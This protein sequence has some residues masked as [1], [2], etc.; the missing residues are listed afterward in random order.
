MNVT[1][2]PLLD[3]L[4]GPWRSLQI[5]V[6]GRSAAVGTMQ[7][8]AMYP[9]S[10]VTD[11]KRQLWIQMDGDPRWA[12]E[13][14]FIGVPQTDDTLRP[15]EFHWSIAVGATLPDPRPAAA[16][17][18]SPALVDEAGNR[19]PIAPTMLGALTLEA[20]LSV[21]LQQG[22]PTLVA[23]CLDELAPAL[24]AD[25]TAQLYQGFYQLYF[26]W[27][28]APEQVLNASR[29]TEAI[30]V[31]YAAAAA[32][33][34]GRTGRIEMVQAALAGNRYI[35][36][37][38]TMHTMVRL[39]W[40]LPIPA[41]RPDS[42]ER[43]FYSLRATPTLPFLRYF[44]PSGKGTPILK[45]GLKDDGAMVIEDPKVMT[46]YLSQPAP[47]TKGGVILGRIPLAS[48]HAETGAAFTLYM[49]EDG[50]TDITFEV[51]QRGATYIAA[52]A[53]DA[54]RVLARV[55]EEMGFPP[56]TQPVLRD[57]HATYN[58][59]HP[60]TR[61]KPISY[62]VL[63]SRVAGLT[64]FFDE[65]PLV[66]QSLG[67]FTWRATSNY[68]SESAIFTYITQFAQVD[69]ITDD[70]VMRRTRY[71]A[72]IT[73]KFGISPEQAA[74]TMERWFERRTAAVAPVP[75]VGAGALAVPK[76]NTG[77]QIVIRGS[78][79]DYRIELQG[80]DNYLEL[81]RVLSVTAVV[82][83]A[84]AEELR[85]SSPSA[86]LAAMDQ[87]VA[88]EDA[89]VEDS[90]AAQGGAPPEEA[91][92]D[93]DQ[94]DAMM[95]FMEGAE[96]GGAD[97]EEASAAAS[98]EAPAAAQLVS[99]AAAVEVAVE[100]PDLAAAV[101]AVSE[102]C[103]GALTAPGEPAL[104]IKPEYYISRLSA[105]D[106]V[107]F[108]YK[109]PKGATGSKKSYARSCQAPD[110]RQPDIMSLAEY[111]RIQ[112][113]YEG[114]VRFVNLPPQNPDDLPTYPDYNPKKK[115]SDEAFKV[116]PATTLPLW[117]VLRTENL[118]TPGTFNYL[119]C[120]EL[121][122]DRDN[123]P[124][125]TSEFESTE[126][127]GFRKPENTC[128][129]CGGNVIE[130]LDAP[131]PG[132]TVIKR[133]AK[134]GQGKVHSFI[135]HLSRGITHPEKGV[136]LPCCHTTPSLLKYYLEEAHYGRLKYGTAAQAAE[137][138]EEEYAEAPP[139]QQEEVAP[140]EEPHTDY[141]AIL[142]SMQ[143]QYILGADKTLSAGKIG[144]LPDYLDEFFGQNG[145]SSI[146][147]T[148]G[149][150]RSTFGEGA[151]VFVRVGVDRRLQQ[152]GL[153]LFAGLTPLMGFDSAEATRRHFL[154]RRMVRA[155]E[156][157]NYGTLVQE[158]AARATVTDADITASLDTWAT[159]NGYTL[160]PSRAHVARLYKAWSAFV[161]YLADQREPKQLRHIEHMLAQPDVLMPRGM[162]IVALEQ[163]EDEKVRVICPSFGI[164]SASIFGDVPVAFMW[165]DRRLDTW[166]PIV[167]YNGT[168]QAVRW[169]GERSADLE[170]LPP[171]IRVSIERW[172]REWR[173]S[174]SGCG[175]P[176]PPPHVWT[177]DRDT[178]GL[179][180]LSTIL[181]RVRGGFHATALVRDRSNRLAGVIMTGAVATGAAAAMGAGAAPR[182][183]L[184]TLDDGTLAT[185]LPRVYEA[186]GIPPASLDAYLQF[187]TSEI[188]SFY[189]SLRPEKIL[190]RIADAGTQVVGFQT[191][192]GVMI[193]VSPSAMPAAPPLPVQQVDLFPWERDALVLRAPDAVAGGVAA[194]EEST[195]SVE[196]Q[197]AEA[198][199]YLRVSVARWLRRD[200]AANALKQDLSMLLSS[201]LPLYERRKRMDIRL[202]PL[203]RSWLAP[204][205]TE[206][207]RTLSLLR[208]DCLS[209]PGEAE[210]RATG[211]CSWSGGRCLIH[212]PYRTEGTDPVRIFTARLSDELLRYSAD[213]RELL[214][215]GVPMIRTP[216]GVV[217]QE[218]ELYIATKPKETAAGLLERLGFMS[219]L[220]A[221]F[222][223]EMLRFA[224][225][226]EATTVGAEED[227]EGAEPA[228]ATQ[229]VRLS[230]ALPSAWTAAGFQVPTP[231]LDLP[232]ARF[233]AWAAGTK[234]SIADWTRY[235]GIRRK[236]LKLPDTTPPRPFQWSVQDFYVL[237]ALTMANMLF[238]RQGA[239]GRLILDR[240]IAPPSIKTDKPIYMVLWGPRQLL[241]TKGT[242]AMIGIYASELPEDLRALLEVSQPIPDAE[243]RGMIE[244]AEVVTTGQPT[245]SEGSVAPSNASEAPPQAAATQGEGDGGAVPAPRPA[246]TL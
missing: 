192:A 200:P 60:E 123:M 73:K 243:A 185:G 206:E 153:N 202:E 135:G 240:W 134:G 168:R 112:R 108:S 195:A 154:S 29:R 246:P 140:V 19:K 215:D 52:V 225:L 226:E 94:M 230:D 28:T 61:A 78:H 233:L 70:A 130:N 142:G 103:R 138:G 5:E 62:K 241:V 82:L 186:E 228:P 242:T 8:D 174:S 79:P 15:L 122:C 117:S 218:N 152:R 193:P 23:I 100:P 113:C 36:D 12:P 50:S 143:T 158:F 75:G 128:P 68:E 197:M 96:F 98:E 59:T 99:A 55:V 177:P 245:E 207:R 69:T 51:P 151:V 105:K 58:W 41:V 91:Q 208:E 181:T 106:N 109:V 46:Q 159:E 212:A 27:L 229:P 71:I 172:I 144:L 92:I 227:D 83:G 85:L 57:I 180:R 170:V 56:G 216:R 171:P 76:H 136:P 190:A 110:G 119:L 111:A 11:L 220:A 88:L 178:S 167:L 38:V 231:A 45:L 219:Q 33:M 244:T 194:I 34:F 48:P 40:I 234:R 239:D 18:P 237:A 9:F 21:E 210:C 223:E 32:Y 31:A 189:P 67:V 129:F 141:T 30:T 214:D 90:A 24:E 221:S 169:F 115:L 120:A 204:E 205:K 126:G 13:R 139:E 165:R 25:L 213:R 191:A 6:S 157:A 179:P 104:K 182:F 107:L 163:G 232:D 146:D 124:L 16:R 64:P 101:A 133:P 20:A 74:A 26:P 235:I 147:K 65:V 49:F 43:T 53:I 37:A 3:N 35:G 164:P 97:D 187:Y 54:S 47:P 148:R 93:F 166:E 224:G 238:V 10:S 173:S 236:A 183:F 4:Q 161:A 162:L 87:Q 86:A 84:P 22:I 7:L 89:Q 81:Q 125:L 42:L 222:P 116:D 131:A 145:A 114:R 217:R 176:S 150:A 72:E 211:T 1:T 203:V 196:E 44:P 95:E 201:K 80:V 209:L 137:G 149:P 127:R 198:Y 155:F 63:K 39:R 199:Q 14:V 77:V 175:R 121:W 17:V 156:S 2:V 102:E 160:G 66:E 188:V 184:P 132:E 118:T